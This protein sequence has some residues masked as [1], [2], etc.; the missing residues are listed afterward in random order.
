MLENFTLI[1][2]R[3]KETT[4][5]KITKLL[6]IL[7]YNYL[8][9]NVNAYLPLEIATNSNV[10]LHYKGKTYDIAFIWQGRRILIEI[11]TTKR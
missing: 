6:A 5:D 1:E 2:V 7:I 11:K 8:S 3:K 10:N 9:K 4:H